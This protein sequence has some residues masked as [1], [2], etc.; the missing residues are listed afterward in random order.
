MEHHG[1]VSIDAL[2]HNEAWFCFEVELGNV[3]FSHNCAVR[4]SAL[5]PFDVHL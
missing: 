4:S 2:F 1:W 3:V 5:L